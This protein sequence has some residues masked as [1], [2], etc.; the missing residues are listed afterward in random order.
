MAL[1]PDEARRRINPAQAALVDALESDLAA[2]D[3]V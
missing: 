1:D 3:A 2:G